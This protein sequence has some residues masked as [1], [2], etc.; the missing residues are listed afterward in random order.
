MFR[1]GSERSIDGT[2][3]A[4]HHPLPKRYEP[5]SSIDNLNV[6]SFLS[7]FSSPLAP[8]YQYDSLTRNISFTPE[9]K[10]SSSPFG[11][12]VL[13]MLDPKGLKRTTN[14][15]DTNERNDSTDLNTAWTSLE[16]T[17][18]LC[19]I[20]YEATAK[21]QTSFTHVIDIVHPLWLDRPCQRVKD[22][23]SMAR[24]KS[25]TSPLPRANNHTTWILD[26][27]RHLRRQE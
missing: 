10:A 17:K 4:D 13:P 6:G 24:L 14:P 5:S 21:Y 3:T 2:H 19:N 27:I 9:K 16:K 8:R 26:L 18:E 15:R 25:C 12:G 23:S 22:I 20:I 11:G 1:Q 7:H